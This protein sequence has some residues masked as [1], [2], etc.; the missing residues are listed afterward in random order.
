MTKIKHFGTIVTNKKIHSGSEREQAET[1]GSVIIIQFRML[2]FCSHI[3][4]KS[5]FAKLYIFFF[6]FY[7]CE[8][9][10]E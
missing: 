4:K 10:V 3:I 6:L 7:F 9:W 2:D 5:K 8:S 1:G